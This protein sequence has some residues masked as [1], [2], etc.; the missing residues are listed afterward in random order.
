VNDSVFIYSYQPLWYVLANR[1][2]PTY[3]QV[4]FFDVAPDDLC[5]RDAERIVKDRPA[6]IVDFVGDSEL[7]NE[8]LFRAGKRSGQRDLQDQMYR[9]IHTSYRLEASIPIKES[10]VPVRVF[11]LRSER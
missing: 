2:P 6:L 9:L 8:N 11:V 7:W 1:W 4:H 3:A 5:R 10:P